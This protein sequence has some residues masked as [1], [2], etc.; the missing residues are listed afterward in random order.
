MAKS[1]KKTLSQNVVNVATTG[2]PQP[3]RKCWVGVLSLC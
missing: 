2:M 1:K 3:V